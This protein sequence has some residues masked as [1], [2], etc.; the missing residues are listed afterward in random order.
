MLLVVEQ[1]STEDQED[2]Y[3]YYGDGNGDEVVDADDDQEDGYDNYGDG[4]GDSDAGDADADAGRSAE[5]AM[6][7]DATCSFTG[8]LN[9]TFVG[10]MQDI[11][12]LGSAAFGSSIMSLA[13]STVGYS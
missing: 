11:L 12:N 6:K 5:E 2:A 1:R 10:D 7:F 9:I 13:A 4:N 8:D 3:D